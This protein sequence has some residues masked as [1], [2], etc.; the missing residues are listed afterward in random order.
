M[1]ATWKV[2]KAMAI[3]GGLVSLYQHA[4]WLTYALA[5][6]ELEIMQLRAAGKSARCRG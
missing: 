6:D 4:N 2:I 3:L 5:S 1:S